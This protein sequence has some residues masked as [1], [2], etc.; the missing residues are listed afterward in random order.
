MKRFL[1]CFMLFAILVLNTGCK[2]SS[3]V[4][5]VTTGLS[6]IA[7]ISYE[8]NIIECS[9]VINKDGVAEITVIKPTSIAG[10]TA[11]LDG[12]T[13]LTYNGLT[14][15]LSGHLPEQNPIYLIYEI[16]SHAE[17]QKNQVKKQDNSYI[18]E[19]E[20]DN[21]EYRIILGESGLPIKIITDKTEI[22]IKNATIC[23]N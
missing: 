11:T 22:L 6:F 7:R 1:S 21:T 2:K 5:A 4:T 9:A 13:A 23:E 20:T 19:G 15:T 8:N 3:A 17:K 12:N 18:L 14:H 16:L 10:L